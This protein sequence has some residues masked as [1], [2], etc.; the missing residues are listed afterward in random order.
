MFSSLLGCLLQ[1]WCGPKDTTQA[2]FPLSLTLI[3]TEFPSLPGTLL[4]LWCRLRLAFDNVRCFGDQERSR[5]KNYVLFASDDGEAMSGMEAAAV[6]L[7][8]EG[9]TG[10]GPASAWDP[11][12]LAA[13]RTLSKAEVKFTF[14]RQRCLAFL[15]LEEEARWG[16]RQ[17]KQAG[18]GLLSGPGTNLPSGLREQAQQAQQ[19]NKGQDGGGQPPWPPGHGPEDLPGLHSKFHPQQGQQTQQPP[20]RKL[21]AIERWKEEAQR[22]QAMAAYHWAVMRRQLDDELW[23]TY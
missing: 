13:L 5:V 10:A 22:G 19:G 20:V 15:G 1:L 6:A 17:A 4:Q 2:P 9:A 8:R 18:G 11:P 23:Q 7:A 3:L 21:W 14:D 16:Q 12:A